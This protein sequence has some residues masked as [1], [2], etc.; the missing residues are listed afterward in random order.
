[1]ILEYEADMHRSSS[2]ESTCSRHG[3]GY[4]GVLEV[5]A[6]RHRCF[7]TPQGGNVPKFVVE[8]K[9]RFKAAS[10]NEHRTTSEI[11]QSKFKMKVR[12]PGISLRL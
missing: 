6:K 10:A 8:P 2:N 1:M 5:S 11:Q 4:H 12:S 7:T 9:P 3:P